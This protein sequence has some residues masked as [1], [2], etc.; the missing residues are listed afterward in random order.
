MTTQQKF[1]PPCDQCR[2]KGC[3]CCNGLGYTEESGRT[4]RAFNQCD[5]VTE[6][7]TVGID[8]ETI[9]R[10]RQAG[11]NRIRWMIILCLVG[12]AFWLVIA[13]VVFVMWLILKDVNQ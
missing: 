3:K 5:I 4:P 11:L 7:V 13:A 1:R 2:G 6:R 9:E 8:G 10:E 12:L